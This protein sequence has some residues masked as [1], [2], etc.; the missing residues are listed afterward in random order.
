MNRNAYIAILFVA[1][2]IALAY[3]VAPPVGI[4]TLSWV[5]LCMN[6]QDITVPNEA[7]VRAKTISDLRMYMSTATVKN[8]LVMIDE[9]EEGYPEFLRQ[10]QERYHVDA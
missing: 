2:I 6:K 4:F 5:M 10:E 8:T 3:Y 1:G 7:L 9:F